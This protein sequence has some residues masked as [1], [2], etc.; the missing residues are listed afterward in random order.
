MDP[1]GAKE[2]DSTMSVKVLVDEPDVPG[3]YLGKVSLG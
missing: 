1:G 2:D 3:L